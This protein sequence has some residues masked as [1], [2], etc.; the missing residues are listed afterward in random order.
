[1]KK[2][3]YFL[4]FFYSITAFA[5]TGVTPPKPNQPPTSDVPPTDQPKI[6]QLKPPPPVDTKKNGTISHTDGRPSMGSD[7]NKII[8]GRGNTLFYIGAGYN[9]LSKSTKSQAFLS[10]AADV[11]LSVYQPLLVR[12]MF[13]FGIQMGVGYC[14]G[15]N[16]NFPS[17]VGVFHVPGETSG[18]VAFKSSGGIKQSAFKFEAGPQ[19]NIHIGNH[20]VISPSL[21]VGAR[22]N[23]GLKEFSTEQTTIFRGFTKTYMLIQKSNTKPVSFVLTPKLRLHYMFNDLIGLWAEVN[24]TFL[25]KIRTSISTFTPEGTPDDEGMYNIEQLDN[26]TIATEQRTTKFSAVGVNAGLIFSF[27]G[28]SKPPI[29]SDKSLNIVEVFDEQ[30]GISAKTITITCNIGNI[31]NDC[32]TGGGLC[33]CILGIATTVHTGTSDDPPTIGGV[34]PDDIPPTKSQENKPRPILG[35]SPPTGII[36]KDPLSDSPPGVIANQK[37]SVT[38]V[39]KSAEPIIVVILSQP[40]PNQRSMKVNVS[41]KNMYVHFVDPLPGDASIFVFDSPTP[42]DTSIAKEL[43][44]KKITIQPGNYKVEKEGKGKVVKLGVVYSLNSE[45]IIKLK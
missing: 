26:G 39:N 42:L 31:K 7:T 15:I 43:G 34:H 35:Q 29:N 19:L 9:F 27:G 32:K 22:I 41:G 13:T 28:K 23:F 4:I 36:V 21:L 17:T 14:I 20:F 5:Q 45:D 18:T 2:Y 11:N 6:V 44:Y 12:K 40:P 33:N 38:V 10:N 37:D 3:I 16:D 25:S 1:M 8:K 24:Y 30:S